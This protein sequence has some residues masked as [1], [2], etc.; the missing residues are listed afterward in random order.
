MIILLYGKDTYRSKRKLKEIIDRYKEAHKR[1]L[2]I[3]F[4]DLEE[5]S[6]EG[7]KDSVR[8]TSMFKEKKLQVV[9]NAFSNK[10]F[11][12]KFLE[13]KEDF[14]N[15]EDIII[16][17]EEGDIRKNDKLLKLLKEKAKVQEFSLLSGS[18]LLS[19]IKKRFKEKG[20]DINNNIAEKLTSFVGND[21]W[22]MENEISKLAS[23]KKGKE[24]KE[25]DIDLLVKPEIETDIFKTIDAIAQKDKKKALS[26]M[27]EHLEKG[28]TPLYLLSMIGYQIRNILSVKEM[29]E[30]SLPYNIALKKTG[31]HPFVFKKSYSQSSSF[32]LV[33]LKKIYQ[34]IFEV[35]LSI[36]V[37]K[38]EAETALDLIVAGI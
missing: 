3:N 16:L 24:I 13:K 9:F 15:S 29:T 17:F 11:K 7:F 8:Q 28:D 6:F 14:I 19:W 32:S 30:K 31:L 1:G 37:G 34:K 22:R 10:S 4:L 26:F 35:D 2:N 25:E 23:Y 38:I 12:E 20:F 33:E 27:H 21:L 36:K 5:E 18:K